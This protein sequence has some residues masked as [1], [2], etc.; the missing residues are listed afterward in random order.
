MQTALLDLTTWDFVLNTNGDLAM[1]S[2]PYSVAQDVASACRT[3]L[4][5]VWYD[6]TIGVDYFQDALGKNQ[7]LSLLRQALI[8]AALTVPGCTNP[9]VYFAAPVGRKLTGQIQFTD[10]NGTTQAVGF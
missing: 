2:D 5:E 10:S 4:G 3:F 6:T 9:V 1:A 8:D 7:P